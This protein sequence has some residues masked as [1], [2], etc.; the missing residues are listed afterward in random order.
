MPLYIIVDNVHIVVY[1]IF[2]IFQMMKQSPEGGI[3][4]VS[5]QPQIGETL[6]WKQNPISMSYIWQYSAN[7][8]SQTHCNHR[9]V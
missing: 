5:L 6:S 7:Y 8:V 9:F 1:K 2:Q 4:D 3:I